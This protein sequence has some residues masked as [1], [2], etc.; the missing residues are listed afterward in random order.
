[1]KI[2]INAGCGGFGLSQVGFDK[3]V[4]LSGTHPASD[5]Q[6]DRDNSHLVKVVELLGTK[7]DDDSASLKV[8]EIP[9]EVKWGIHEYD[10]KEHIFEE[11]RTWE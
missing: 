5:Y 11:H 8:V 4:E 1:M 2:V 9:D 7:A 10:G 3:F 6:I